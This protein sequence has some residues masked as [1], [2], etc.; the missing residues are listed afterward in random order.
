[1]NSED[2]RSLLGPKIRAQST[3]AEQIELFEEL[4]YLPLAIAQAVAF[5]IKRR[6][7]IRQYLE[8]Y[9]QNDSTRIKMLGQKS[10]YHGREGRPLESVVHTWWLS[11]NY[12]KS[13]NTRA[14]ELLSMMSFLDRQSIP[15]ILMIDTDEDTF[16]FDEAI[17]LL[18]SFSLIARTSSGDTSNMHRLVQVGTRAW[19]QEI[20]GSAETTALA[21]LSRLTRF[22]QGTYENWATC[23]MY[24]PH[25]DAILQY[26]FVSDTREV[27]RVRAELLVLTAAY[28]RRQG[29]FSPA[30]ERSLEAK[31]IRERLLGVDHEDTLNSIAEYAMSLQKLGEYREAVKL[32]RV[33][34]AGR[35]KVSG[36]SIIYLLAPEW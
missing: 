36:W 14:A 29:R 8:S 10:M 19:L 20:E 24:L 5:M 12:I 23:A 6:K 35:E 17:G 7:N 11:F 21:A 9:R 33:V 25:A 32:Q 15:D 26:K 28:L 13:E 27:K 22:P 2:A 3:E 16:D 4:V 31:N 34:L 18:D 1:M 30:K